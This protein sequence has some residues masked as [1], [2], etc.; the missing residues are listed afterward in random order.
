MVPGM[1]ST[2]NGDAITTADPAVWLAAL[3]GLYPDGIPDDL[4]LDAFAG[5]GGWSEGFRMLGPLP[6]SF[7]IASANLW[8]N[9][10]ALA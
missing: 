10:S 1:S 5:P 3:N 7:A 9:V 6:C 8:M 4:T 2:A